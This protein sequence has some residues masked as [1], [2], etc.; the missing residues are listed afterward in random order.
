M[1]ISDPSEASGNRRSGEL[2]VVIASV[3][4]PVG[5]TG[6]QTHF[7][8]FRD[9]LQTRGIATELITS[10]SSP[11]V[12][13]YPLFAPRKALEPL[14]GSLG[15]WWYFKWH[16]SLLRREL[17]RRLENGAPAVVYAQSPTAARAALEARRHPRQRVVMA[18]HFGRSEASNWSG[19][20]TIPPHGA[21]ARAIRADEQRTIPRVDALV[22]VS[23]ASRQDLLE[24][25]PA[26]AAIPY[27]IVPNFLQRPA[28]ADGEPRRDLITIGTLEHRKNQS[29]LVDVV[30]EARALGRE[31][32]LT[33]IGDGPDRKD[34][35]AR[36]TARGVSDLIHFAGYLSQAARQIPKHRLY[37]HSASYESFCI[38]AAEGLSHGRPVIAGAVGGLPEVY[39]DGIEGRFWPLDS[40]RR[41]AEILIEVL[42]DRPTYDRMAAAA[43]SRFETHF[44]ADVVVPRLY[45]FLQQV[46]AAAPE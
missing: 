41:G 16:R 9:Q 14:N 12:L 17:R 15:V 42:E 3:M 37:V 1:P 39:D 20:G 34:L 23:E 32:T 7:R 44:D 2:P 22:A 8:Q 28:I 27:R 4:R 31:A 25:V 5:E 38:A 45:E 40:P 36:A 11:A 21:M 30:A 33:M 46:G 6:V 10:F 43:R 13:R 19:R 24:A 18:V 35:E 26:A 29:Y